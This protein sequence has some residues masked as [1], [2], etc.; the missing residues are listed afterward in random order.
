MITSKDNPTVKL[1]RALGRNKKIR[2]EKQLFILENKHFIKE[3]IQTK[4]SAIKTI[5]Y[6]ENNKPTNI[7]TDIETIEIETKLF[8]QINRTLHK[9]NFNSNLALRFK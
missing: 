2:H 9:S 3:W 5:L 6:T 7:P 1:A 8:S 4:P